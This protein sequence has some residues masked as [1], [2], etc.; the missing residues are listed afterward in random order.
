MFREAPPAKA[1]VLVG[2]DSTLDM[3]VDAH[4]GV[5]FRYLHE[6][7]SSAGSGAFAGAALRCRYAKSRR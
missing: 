1:E 5:L 6:L 3:A 7:A 2:S 4:A